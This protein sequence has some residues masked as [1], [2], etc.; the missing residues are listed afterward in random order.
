MPGHQV[1]GGYAEYLVRDE[2]EWL[3]VPA[4]LPLDEAAV[5][6]WSFATSHRVIVDR[7]RVNLGDTVLVAGA[8]RGMGRASLQLA[9]L[10]GARVIA[11][12]R[13]E[14]KAQSL[15]DSADGVVVTHD[16]EKAAAEVRAL[17][18]GHGVEHAIDYTGNRDVLAFMSS[19]LRPGGQ[20]LISAG[21][22][23]SEPVP[24]RPAQFLVQEMTVLGIRAARAN[25]ARMV[26]ILAGQC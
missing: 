26:L 16:L 13:S 15:L 8:S 5:T 19:V 24:F 6:I 9:K 7:L 18:D 10:V 2:T 20:I 4:S 22:G 23:S 21:E 25:D 17:T 12:T 14:A 3:A 1:A 11:T